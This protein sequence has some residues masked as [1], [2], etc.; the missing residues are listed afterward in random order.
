MKEKYIT[1]TGMN[2]YYGLLPFKVG[3]KFTCKKDKCN[4]Y[5]ADAIKVIK[6]HIG[7][8]GYVANIPYTSATGTL[9]ASRIHSKVKKE[10]TVEVMFITSSKVICKV[11]SGFKEKKDKE[12]LPPI[13]QT[14]VKN[15]TKEELA[16][17]NPSE[18]EF[19][20]VKER[21]KVLREAGLDPKQ[22]DF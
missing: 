10:F 7:T 5:D 14:I 9:T 3:K 18:L 8:V 6:K 15:D 12:K 2:H 16:G 17:I 20:S 4:P 1:I 22:Y 21:E 13:T 11:I 19:M